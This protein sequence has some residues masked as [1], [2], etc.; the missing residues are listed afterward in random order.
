MPS[1][2]PT[3][4]R[5]R[6]DAPVG[7][8]CAGAPCPPPHAPA[9]PPANSR[10]PWL[11]PTCGS[12]PPTQPE[13][14]PGTQEPSCL[15]A[16][17]GLRKARAAAKRGLRRKSPQ[18]GRDPPPQA[19][20]HGHAVGGGREG[21][22]DLAALPRAA[23]TYASTPLGT[24]RKARKRS[25]T[26]VR[27]HNSVEIPRHSLTY[28]RVRL[29]TTEKRAS[30]QKWQPRSSQAAARQLC[31]P[32][33]LPHTLAPHHPEGRKNGQVQKKHALYK[34]LCSGNEFSCKRAAPKSLYRDRI[35]MQ[36]LLRAGLC[37][38]H[39]PGREGPGNR[40]NRAPPPVPHTG[41]PPGPPLRAS[42]PRQGLRQRPP[43]PARS[44]SGETCAL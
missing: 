10:A 15:A 39:R 11:G 38:N 27:A 28:A 29:G 44:R 17:P 7:S 21:A 42:A 35:H 43:A 19:H 13:A 32:T 2:E 3:S 9:P 40:S 1:P 36:G 12:A 37:P 16:H 30:R 33:A 24:A 14:G 5:Q 22:H 26:E 23:L 18:P 20:L 4:E 25:S 34:R 41:S 31:G 6:N 8:K